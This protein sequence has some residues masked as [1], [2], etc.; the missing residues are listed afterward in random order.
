MVGDTSDGGPSLQSPRSSKSCVTAI[1]MSR[2]EALAAAAQLLS[3]TRTDHPN[4]RLAQKLQRTMTRNIRGWVCPGLSLKH[5][6]K[7]GGGSSSSSNH[8][9][10]QDR[11]QAEE[12]AV[13]LLARP[14]LVEAA[15]D[16]TAAAGIGENSA[17]QLQQNLYSSFAVLVDSRLHAY[18]A[19]LARH[20]LSL[21][22]EAEA[23]SI[24]E[25]LAEILL[26]GSQMAAETMDTRFT[27][28]DGIY[29]D[30]DDEGSS[31]LSSATLTLHVTLDLS[32]P[33]DGSKQS[34]EKKNI[35]VSF[36]ITGSIQGTYGRT[37]EC[38]IGALLQ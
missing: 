27:T 2:E 34:K 18:S 29:D 1:I 35:P 36:E 26:V 24:R 38:W 11:E 33:S 3:L 30:D 14:L 28:G 20:A 9:S 12:H 19:F 15:A 21:S 4:S 37:V 16:T 32:I 5:D 17:R 13:N 8:S 31:P 23:A 6:A 25:K 22:D 7:E 10:H